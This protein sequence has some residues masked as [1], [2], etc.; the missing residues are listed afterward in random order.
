[1]NYWLLKSEPDTFSW[2][3]QVAL[4]DR[5]GAWDGVRNHQ[6]AG[7]LKA[8]RAGDRAFFYHTGTDRCIVGIAEVTQAA[9]ADPTDASGRFVAVGIRAL[10]PLPR[11]VGL[12][13]IK[14]RPE[15]GDFLLVRHSRLSVMPV[16]PAQWRLICRMAKQ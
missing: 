15:L 7:Y 4:G 14:A 6:A 3:E 10:E 5:G 9:F 16:T 8:M 13:E 1:M 12:A 2:A 11:P